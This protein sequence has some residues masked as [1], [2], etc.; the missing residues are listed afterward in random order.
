MS[1][2]LG[3]IVNP[4][5]GMGGAVGLKGTDGERHAQ[6]LARGAGPL[7]HRRTAT[8][9]AALNHVQVAFKLLTAGGA[10][11]AIAAREAG[12]EHRV[13]FEPAGRHTTAADTVAAAQA[14]ALA[15]IDLLLFAGGD[16]TARDLLKVIDG[17]IPVLG[18]PAG[19]KM[20]SAVFAPGPAAA[21]DIAAAFL[22]SHCSPGSLVD[23]EVM[24]RQ[25]DESS[26]ELYGT[27]RV[28]TN[29]TWSPHPKAGAAGSAML[30]GAIEHTAQLARDERLTLIGP[31]ATMQAIKQRLGSNGTLLGVDAFEQGRLVEA[32]LTAERCLTLLEERRGR[33]G[34]IIVGI[35]GGQGFLFG[36]GNQQ[37]SPAVI[38][39]VGLNGI[40]V[41]AAVEKLTALAGRALYV[42][43][44]DE[45]LDREFAGYISVRTGARR[46]LQYRVAAPAG[47][48]EH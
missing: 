15:G 22:Q 16:G 46:S 13:V 40:V 7:S 11:G 12:I 6:A 14:L 10:M 3:L 20:H 5:A 25:D 48:P 39:R 23:A 42:D 35:V 8:A 4:V 17:R 38:R 45:S 1:Y 32:D 47:A 33:P 36:R 19:V 26:P 28:P 24:D 9:L 18:I 34:R 43:T 41:V 29:A 2:R 27:L 30:N 37:F 44:G 31:G 21:G